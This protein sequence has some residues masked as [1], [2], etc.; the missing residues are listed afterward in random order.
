MSATPWRV[1]VSRLVM[2]LGFVALAALP[3][4]AEA[5][6]PTLLGNDFDG[7]LFDVDP[8]TGEATHPRETNLSPLLGVALGPDGAAYAVG[9]SGEDFDAY[10]YRIDPAT[11][12]SVTV[13]G[14]EFPSGEGD[15]AFQPGTGALVALLGNR[16]ADPQFPRLFRVDTLT[17]EATQLSVINT[18]GPLDGSAMAFKPDGTLFIVDTGR[19]ETG[20]A[21]RLLTVD[22]ATGAV[23]ASVPLPDLGALAGA[24]FDPDSARL[25]VADGGANGTLRLYSVDPSTGSATTIGATGEADEGL[26]GL[27]AAFVPEPSSAGALA[28]LAPLLLRRRVRA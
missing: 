12:S 17:G 21:E 14:L 28:A 26:A 27:T 8:A 15:L 22:P 10:L 2:G 11:G 9:L 20:D 5:L 7:V 6:P 24:V 18:V 4:H 16:E 19:A 3:K 1:R 25:L 23:L 13:G